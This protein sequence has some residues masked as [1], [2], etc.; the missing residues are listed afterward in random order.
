MKAPGGRWERQEMG[1]E[2]SSR[3]MARCVQ[4]QSWATDTHRRV[5]LLQLA[6]GLGTPDV[7]LSLEKSSKNN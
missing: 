5:H 7:C 3:E 2:G 4:G 6:E 1:E